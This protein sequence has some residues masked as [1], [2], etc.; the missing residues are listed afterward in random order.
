MTKRNEP[1]RQ[2]QRR[3]RTGVAALFARTSPPTAGVLLSVSPQQASV[4]FAGVCIML[5]LSACGD[6][7]AR[8]AGRDT[9]TADD[10]VASDVQNDAPIDT[11]PMLQPGECFS[12]A[13]CSAVD[14]EECRHDGPG[15]CETP[16]TC[17]VRSPLGIDCVS[18]MYCG[19]DGVTYDNDCESTTGGVRI[20]P[21]ACE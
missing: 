13:D 6:D 10:V 20:V 8:D 12:S 9:S 4:F 3:Q 21:G 18:G 16:G 11:G 7:D 15:T 1:I 17:T 19:C 2:T 5:A 14:D